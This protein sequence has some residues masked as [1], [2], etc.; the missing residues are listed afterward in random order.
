MV[1]VLLQITITL[2]QHSRFA[3]DFDDKNK[4]K[5]EVQRDVRNS[6][7]WRQDKFR[8]DWSHYYNTCS[9]KV[10]QN[11]VSGGVSVL[12]WHAAPV[13]NVLWKPLAIR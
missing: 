6:K 11:S 3:T 5:T 13:A 1:S 8:R 12:C 10:G 7:V 2:D 4:V 9:P